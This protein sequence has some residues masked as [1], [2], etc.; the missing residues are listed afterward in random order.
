V[1]AQDV[2]GV[3]D[4]I[5]LGNLGVVNVADEGHDGGDGSTGPE[6]KGKGRASRAALDLPANLSAV[7]LAK[8]E[9]GIDR[10]CTA[11]A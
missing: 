9:G 1:D 4:A 7:A 11:T 3:G 8:A 5:G 2:V 6:S 10:A